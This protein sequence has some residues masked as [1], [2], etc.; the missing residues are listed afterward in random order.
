[1]LA[2]D[3]HSWDPCRRDMGFQLYGPLL[4][5]LMERGEPYPVLSSC[6]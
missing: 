3:V 5:S 2:W 4:H 1:M 6:Q